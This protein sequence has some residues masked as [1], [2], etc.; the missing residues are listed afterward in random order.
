MSEIAPQRPLR[1]RLLLSAGGFLLGLF[2]GSVTTVTHQSVVTVAG[3]DVP[4]GLIL[5]LLVITGFLVGLRIVVQDRLVVL[6]AALGLVV[7][8]FI[9]SQASTGGSVLIPNNLWGTI[10]AIAPTLIATIVVA[11]PRLPQRHR[12]ADNG[13]AVTA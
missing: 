3:V 7:M 2:V 6:I 9:L 13:T 8:V 1:T 4:W 5:G 11:W 10:W 12:G